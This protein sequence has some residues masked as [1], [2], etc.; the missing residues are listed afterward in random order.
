MIAIIAQLS[1][2][3]ISIIGLSMAKKPRI[4]GLIMSIPDSLWPTSKIQSSQKALQKFFRTIKWL[5]NN[6]CC[7]K[8][9]IAS[10]SKCLISD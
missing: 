5:E 4:I 3:I 2:I 7:D 10:K 9:T 1:I 8:I 6:L